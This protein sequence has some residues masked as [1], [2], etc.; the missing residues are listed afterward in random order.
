MV[1]YPVLLK[2]V[3]GGFAAVGFAV[4]FNTGRN[5]LYSIFLIGFTGILVRL[6]LNTG[7]GLNIVIASFLAA[8]AN[9]FIS[10]FAALLLKKPPLVIAIP[11]AIPMVP[12]IFLYR[13]MLGIVRLT[14]NSTDALSLFQ[15]DLSFTISNGS[16]A[17]FILMGLAIG[18]S[19]PYLVFRKH[20]LH[21]MN[22][23]FSAP[24]FLNKILKK[25]NNG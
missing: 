21:Y 3:G 7:M 5:I 8:S 9:G 23:G 19:M 18:I 12:G 1:D 15:Q 11:A 17:L 24:A 20:S 10:H 13:M 4:L 25:R 2:A 22:T 16:K 6:V 14:G